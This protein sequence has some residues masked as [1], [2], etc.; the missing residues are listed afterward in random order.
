MK[1]IKL[2]TSIKRGEKEITE[3]L[4]RE[5]KSGELRGLQLTSVFQM[6][7]GTMLNLIPR[8]SDL[9]PDELVALPIRDFTKLCV[10]TLG[11]FGEGLTG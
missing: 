1:Q 9:T 7:T 11:F 10:E 3:V 2:S 8:I 6:D 4:L 5:P